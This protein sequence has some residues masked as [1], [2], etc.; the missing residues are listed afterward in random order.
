MPSIP[1]RSSSSRE[2]RRSADDSKRRTV[3]QGTYY[4]YTSTSGKRRP[5]LS[6]RPRSRTR[7]R[8]RDLNNPEIRRRS[9]ERSHGRDRSRSR[10][11]GRSQ[12]SQ[13]R[14]RAPTPP[15]LP[16]SFDDPV[17]EASARHR[18]QFGSIRRSRPRRSSSADWTSGFNSFNK[19][20]Q[21][22]FGGTT[23]SGSGQ[24]RHFSEKSG[25]VSQNPPPEWQYGDFFVRM[26]RELAEDD[27]SER[28]RLILKTIATLFRDENSWHGE[29]SGRRAD[30]SW[31]FQVNI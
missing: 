18:T 17:P 23:G 6:R 2:R 15:W 22:E 7:S 19:D 25:F 26:N 16:D 12:E 10:R 5:S 9:R 14:K 3:P 4:G 30:Y 1:R 31:Q 28:L 20:Q 21:F 29:R 24:D 27:S 13:L 8:S 11:R